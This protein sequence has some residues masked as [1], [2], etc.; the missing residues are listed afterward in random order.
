MQ[1]QYLGGEAGESGWKEEL[2]GS[3]NQENHFTKHAEVTGSYSGVVQSQ[4]YII[5]GESK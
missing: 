5:A 2:E 4:A 1:E 3:E